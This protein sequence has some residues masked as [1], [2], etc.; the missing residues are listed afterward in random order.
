MDSDINWS[1]IVDDII[2][3]FPDQIKYRMTGHQFRG[4]PRAIQS[5]G[6]T[7]FSDE[8]GVVNAIR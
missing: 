5:I 2:R 6:S 4:D 7:H 3:C 8:I 1:R